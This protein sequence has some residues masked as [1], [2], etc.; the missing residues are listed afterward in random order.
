MIEALSPP[1]RAALFEKGYV[2]LPGLVPAPL[3]QEAL[4]AINGS[5]GRGLW[6]E[7]VPV[8]RARSFCP[9]LQRQPVTTDR[10]CR[11]PALALVES[12]L[13]RGCL[14]RAGTGQIALAFPAPPESDRLHPHLDGLHTPANGV[15]AGSLLSFTLLL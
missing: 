1:Q 8:F 7:D 5:L 2:T 15:P 3:W 14:E 13:G 12:L 6:P 4:R 9:E 11:S 10:L